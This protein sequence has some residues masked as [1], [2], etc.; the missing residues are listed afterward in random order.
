MT[1]TIIGSINLNG[2]TAALM[3]GDDKKWYKSF[4]KKDFQNNDINNDIY[5]TVFS[6]VTELTEKEF[7]TYFK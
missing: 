6:E 5:H 2:K 7:K 4:I 1:Y 3:V